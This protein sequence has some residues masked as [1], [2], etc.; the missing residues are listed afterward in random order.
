VDVGGKRLGWVNS[1][2]IHP[3]SGGR[4]RNN[5]FAGFAYD[6]PN[7]VFAG[8]DKDSPGDWK[9]ADYNCFYNPD[10]QDL[11]RYQTASFGAHDC[12]GS[13]G[14][15]DPK[16]AQARIIPFPFGDGD[17]W[18]RHVTVSQILAFYRGMYTPG[19]GSPLIDQGDPTDD[20]GGARNTD[21]GAVGAGSPHPDDLFG[22][23]GK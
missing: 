21:I 17:I 2:L 13:A 12:G 6:T 10:A 22:T 15:A 20:T 19:P 18:Q 9:E 1:A 3:S 7:A 14:S 11:T 4:A 16:F 8:P 23:F 5:V